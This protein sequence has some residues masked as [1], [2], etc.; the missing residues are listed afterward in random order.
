MSICCRP[1]AVLAA[2]VS[3]LVL[4]PSLQ[5]QRFGGGG[6]QL[7]RVGPLNFQYVGPQ[8]AGR[9]ASAAGVAG[10][11]DVFY[12]GAAS[13]GVWKT[14]DG[15]ET[16][17]PVFDEQSVQAVGALAVSQS[18]P[19]V[20][21]AGTGEAW[22]IRDADIMGDGVYRS[23]DGGATW[24]HMGLT[25]T[26][27]IGRIVI[28]PTN[29]DEVF[30]CALGRTTGPQ[31]ERGVY[32]TMDGGET[33]ERVLFVDE[34]TGCSGLAMDANDPDVLYAGTWDVV[35][36]T[37]VMYSG[38]PGSGV[39]RSTDG[40]DTWEHLENG[41]PTSPYGK[42]DV[43]VAPT[44][45]NRVYA[46]IQTAAQGS[47]WR[48]DDAGANWEVVSW[49]RTLIGRAGYYIRIAVN[50]GNQN[51]LLIMSSS[52]H[53]SLDGGRTWTTDVGGCGDCHDVWMDP[54]DPNHWIETGDGGAGST[55]DH[56]R[57]FQRVSLPI[58]QMYHVA[59]DDRTPYWI[60]SNRQD[61]GT[62]RGPSDGPVAVPNVPSYAPY[63][64]SRPWR[65]RRVRR[66][67]RIG[68]ARGPRWL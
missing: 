26:G 12:L 25:E 5:A 35:M 23:T 1:I 11:P 38:G 46:L 57:S 19:D 36:H 49:D 34:D 47:V 17:A 22:A 27:R 60:Y 51:E 40:G 10:Q 24:R 4:A 32:R 61:D 3:L 6:T 29:P 66:R 68:L 37:W 64:P 63:R 53:R 30:V 13:G 16:F 9:F 59:V 7:D 41:L 18:D 56:G 39:Y 48:S 2:F 33:W 67:W 44:N 42:V 43:A 28:H 65:I 8:S 54:Y 45:S 58:G 31:Q 50:P 15:G 52:A 14:S 21:W 55:T 20:V 62:M